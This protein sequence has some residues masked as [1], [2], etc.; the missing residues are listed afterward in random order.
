MLGDSYS[1][2]DYQVAPAHSFWGLTASNLEVET[3]LNYSWPGSNLDSIVHILI[4]EQNKID[5]AQDFLLIG[6]PPLERLTVFDNFK[7]T[8]YNF[9]QFDTAT[10][11]AKPV[12]LLCHTGLE[13]IPGWKA[14]KMVVYSDRSWTETQTLSKLFLLATWLDSV[15]ASYLVA[16]LSKPL[17]ENNIWGPTEFLLP[18]AKSRNNMILFNDTYYSVNEHVHKPADFDQHGWWGHHGPAG[19]KNFFETSIKNRLC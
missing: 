13:N 17:D 18:W 16:N 12:P 14:E 7:D 1:T 11:T 9:N 5:W 19:N 3:V 8:K 15:G 10:W 4:S 6:I 2:P